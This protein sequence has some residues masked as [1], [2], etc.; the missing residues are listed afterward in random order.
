MVIYKS[1]QRMDRDH[2][3]MGIALAVRKRANCLGRRV[4][5][6]IVRDDRVMTT[7]YNGVPSNM[8]NCD[9]DGWRTTVG[10]LSA[11]GVDGSGLT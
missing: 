5:A 3:Y 1:A 8:P 11:W 4:G 6:V 7:G 2:Y 9:E 10:G